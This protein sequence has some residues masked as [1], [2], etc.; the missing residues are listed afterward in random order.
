MFGSFKF[1]I[2]EKEAI[3]K[4]G[5]GIILFILRDCI[6]V[7]HPSGG[8]LSPLLLALFINSLS[9]HLSWTKF[10]LFTHG[11][12]QFLKVDST[13]DQ[14]VLQSESNLFSI[15]V[16]RLGLTL[17]LDKCHS[18]TFTNYSRS[19]A[20]KTYFINGLSL[21]QKYLKLKTSVSFIRRLF[22]LIIILTL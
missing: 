21:T 8:H 10:L 1:Y 6:S 12:K 15:W 4:S 17:N 14:A 22:H 5:W 16:D 19:T 7:R 2:I 11:I 13:A 18:I 3:Y 20:N 9:Q